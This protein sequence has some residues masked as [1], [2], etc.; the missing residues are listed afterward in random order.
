MGLGLPDSS[1]KQVATGTVPADGGRVTLTVD[2]QDPQLTLPRDRCRGTYGKVSN[3]M[4]RVV[5]G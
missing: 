4:S 1:S 2:K 5:S 3:T